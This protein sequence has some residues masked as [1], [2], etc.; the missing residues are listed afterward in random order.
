MFL[1]FWGYSNSFS[2]C[3]PVDTAQ[4]NQSFRALVKGP[5]TY[6]K[7]KAFFDAF[8]SSF[9]EFMM[10]YGYFHYPKFDKTM[11]SKGND[12]INKGLTMLNLIPD[13]TYCDK[14]ISLGISGQWDADAPT[15]LQELLH[16]TMQNH[17]NTMFQRLSL[18]WHSEQF[19]FWF[20]YF[21]SPLP[22]QL[23][24]NDFERIRNLEKDPFPNVVKEME[25]AFNVSWGNAF[26]PYQSRHI[27]LPS[28][29]HK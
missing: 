21:N 5:N 28:L 26:Q 6:K 17:L 25:S 11:Y 15:Y 22:T 14:L 2:Q 12:H 20:F 27:K 9:I 13:T 3:Y 16:K 18:K 23:Y 4:L 1:L 8:P 24:K 10:V 19:S 29:G 7:Q